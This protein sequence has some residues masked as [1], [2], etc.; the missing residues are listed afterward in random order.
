MATASAGTIPNLFASDIYRQ[1]LLLLC[2]AG[3]D[4]TSE[5]VAWTLYD[6]TAAYD[7]DGTD[8]LT[9]DE[10]PFPSVLAAM[11]AGWR[12]L[13]VPEIKTGREADEYQLGALP[14]EW[15]LE[16]WE[17]INDRINN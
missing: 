11:R 9:S 3:A 15:H 8:L 2:S 12:V 17:R 13:K 1:K 16:L 4:A 5:I 7:F 6:G 14:Y 10:P